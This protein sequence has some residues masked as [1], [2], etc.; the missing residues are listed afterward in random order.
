MLKK[1]YEKPSRYNLKIYGEDVWWFVSLTD[2]VAGDKR[3]DCVVNHS[4]RRKGFR[5]RKGLEVEK[6]SSLDE[7]VW[8]IRM[9]GKK[10]SFEFSKYKVV[11]NNIEEGKRIVKAGKIAKRIEVQE[12]SIEKIMR[13][14]C[15]SNNLNYAYEVRGFIYGRIFK[16][17]G[18]LR[19]PVPLASV[20]NEG[21]NFKTLRNIVTDNYSKLQRY[22]YKNRGYQYFTGKPPRSEVGGFLIP[23][24]WFDSIEYVS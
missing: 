14:I 5:T 11:K 3:P 18:V 10:Y 2:P 9:E 21:S 6:Y 23:L 20:L 24:K 19:K 15:D 4:K 16:L 13:I 7:L 17:N 8:D 22:D 1:L 12:D